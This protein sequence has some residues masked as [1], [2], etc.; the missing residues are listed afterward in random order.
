M[1]CL[2][3]TVLEET[4]HAVSCVYRNN[5]DPN[6][7]QLVPGDGEE[8]SSVLPFAQELLCIWKSSMQSNLGFEELAV[9]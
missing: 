8:L 6:G 9:G 2:V 5:R 4:A 3:E 7:F 1:V